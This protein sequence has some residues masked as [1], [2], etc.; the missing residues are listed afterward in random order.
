M[1]F[2]DS[3]FNE[4]V[5][6]I[7]PKNLRVSAFDMQIWWMHRYL[8]SYCQSCLSSGVYLLKHSIFEFIEV[9]FWGLWVAN[10]HHNCSIGHTFIISILLIITHLKAKILS[11]KSSFE[12]W[13]F[14]TLS[15][16]GYK[17]N[18]EILKIYL[19]QIMNNL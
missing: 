6:V 19:L 5:I 9:S 2:E 4:N 11:N 3:S 18:F 1:K 13:C 14:K 7:I 10:I 8:K 15:I 16:T 12:L 17:R